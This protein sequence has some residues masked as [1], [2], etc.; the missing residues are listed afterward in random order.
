[1]GLAQNCQGYS[2]DASGMVTGVQ[3]G[4]TKVNGAKYEVYSVELID[5][6]S[7]G[8]NTVAYCTVLD[9]NNIPNAEQ[10][11]LTWAGKAPPF[12]DS[13]LAGNGRNEHVI[14]NKYNPP[15]NG[16]LALHTGGFNAPTSDIV[17]G[18]GLPFGHHV[19]FRVIFREKGATTPTDPTNPPTDLTVV[20]QRLDVLE[21]QVA[22]HEA[23]LK[24]LE[25]TGG[26]GGYTLPSHK[27]G[28]HWIPVPTNYQAHKD[29]IKALK[30]AVIKVVNGN[31]GDLE[32][33][34]A[35]LDPGG[36]LVVRDHARSEQQDF[37]ARDPV[38][39]GK[40]HAL[41]W[42]KDF[43]VGGKYYGI[44]TDRIVVCG[45][46]EPFVRDAVEEKKVLDYTIAFLTDLKAYG[47]RGLCLNLSVGWVR[48][49]GANTR[50]FWGT[51]LPLERIINEGNHIL[52]LH[53]YWY[54][55]P[56]DS[57]TTIDGLEF[58]W[59]GQRH[60]ACPLQ[61]PI[62]IGECGLTKNIDLVRWQN[63]GRPPKGWIGNVSPD[64]YA[65]QLWRYARK[66]TPN[67]IGIM[68]FTTGYASNDWAEDDTT[69][70][71]PHILRRKEYYNFPDGFPIVPKARQDVTTNPPTNPNNL[72]YPKF[73]GKISGYY[74]QLYTN[75]SGGKYAHE[76]LDISTPTGT[77]VYAA[78]DGV[79]AWSDVDALYG[80]YVRT[81]HKALNVCFFYAHLSRRVV[82][83]GA[84]VKQGQLIGYSGN[85]GNS[86]GPHLHFE[87][88]LMKFD[89]PIYQPGVSPH[90]NSRIDPIAFAGGWVSNGGTIVE[91]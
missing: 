82:Q 12:A 1:M 5:E 34:L 41:E 59:T 85:S 52:G 35:N 26:A 33:C 46:N 9:K 51:F 36:V 63:D 60:W 44:P 89:T 70:A 42:K 87:V 11:R 10:V 43:S 74:G 24:K 2:Q 31:K 3:L 53:E 73:S 28:C 57:W 48:N 32:Y 45:L 75:S 20:N 37:L 49:T 50:P 39:C 86:T 88:R 67:V 91:K 66:C 78:Y 8:G 72:I 18:L 40:Q 16:P 79:V 29:Y 25:A 90:S 68:P 81:Y 38:G 13:G 4:I 55:D 76:G 15:A 61:V 80:E 84:T 19:S 64:A 65:E 47:L 17:W 71:H 14:I 69:A 22:D 27:M 23:R 6:K 21:K 7:A 77:P 62:I 58:G 56:D 83:N 54:G 30:P